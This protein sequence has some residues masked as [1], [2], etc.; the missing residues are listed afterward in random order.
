[1]LVIKYYYHMCD[2]SL[3]FNW[4]FGP[5]RLQD[6]HLSMLLLRGGSLPPS[7]EVIIVVLY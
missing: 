7:A 4:I 2:V 3:T 1:M 6:V 5:I